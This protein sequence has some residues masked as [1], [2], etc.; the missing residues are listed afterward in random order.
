MWELHSRKWHEKQQPR[1]EH[2]DESGDGVLDID[3][4]GPVTFHKLLPIANVPI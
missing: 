1:F 2:A 3:A 4:R